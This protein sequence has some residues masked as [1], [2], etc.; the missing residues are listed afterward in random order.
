MK[1]IILKISWSANSDLQL[2]ASYHLSNGQMTLTALK[3]Q[4]LEL[5]RFMK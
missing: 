5:N 2:D 4:R 3:K 1:T